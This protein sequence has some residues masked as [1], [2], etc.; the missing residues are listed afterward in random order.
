M[1][2]EAIRQLRQWAPEPFWVVSLYLNVDGRQRTRPEYEAA[3][4]NLLAEGRGKMENCPGPREVRQALEEDLERIHRYVTQE[5]RNQGRRGLV[6]FSCT[7]KG[8]WAAMGTPL[9]VRDRIVLAPLPYLRP[10]EAIVEEYH[11]FGVAVCDSRRARFFLLHMGELQEYSE[12][13]DEVPSRV[14]EGGWSG[15]SEARIGR[16]VEWH[17]QQHL[18]RVAA[19]LFEFYK[20]ENFGH[21]ILGGPEEIVAALESA[22]HSYLQKI[23]VGRFSAAV[24]ASVEEIRRLAM[25]VERRYDE[26]EKREKVRSLLGKARSQSYGVVGLADTLEALA[27]GAVHTLVVLQDLTL[28]GKVCRGCGALGTPES[29]QCRFCGGRDLAE[30]GDVVAEAIAEAAEQRCEVVRVASSP[31]LEAVGGFGAML[32]FKWW[33]RP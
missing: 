23:V 10:L 1:T 29:Q 6:L 19:A 16:H 20:Q 9:P 11:T 28:P 13:L 18:H 27:M 4:K 7:G 15:Y 21:L 26:Q 24:N 25:E 14:R 32:R 33:E 5:F 3:L 8:L 31:E 22:L 17:V 12:M 2:R 30:V